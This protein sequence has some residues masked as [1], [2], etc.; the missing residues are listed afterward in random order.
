MKIKEVK[1]IYGDRMQ[2]EFDYISRFITGYGIDV[3]CGTNRL[4][5]DVLAIDAFDHRTADFHTEEEKLNSNDIVHDCKDLNIDPVEWHG[6]K[7]TFEDDSLDFI[8]SSHCLEDFE[9]I[10]KVFQEWWEKLKPGGYMLLLLPDMETGRYPKVGSPNGNPSHRTDVGKKY[11]VKMLDTL[12]ID[13]KMIQADTIPHDLSCSIDFVILKE[14][15][16]HG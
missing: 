13:Y 12:S 7:Y 10:P 11:I 6:H 16:N 8:F 1:N 3:G 14:R 4:S 2:K 9:D 15:K 5:P